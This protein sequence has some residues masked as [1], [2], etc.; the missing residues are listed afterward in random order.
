MPLVTSKFD[1]VYS[2]PRTKK[3]EHV[4]H[5]HGT[6]NFFSDI[7]NDIT[8]TSNLEHPPHSKEKIIVPKPAIDITFL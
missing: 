8:R 3:Q 1:F 6:Q 2:N 7:L 4:K 5:A